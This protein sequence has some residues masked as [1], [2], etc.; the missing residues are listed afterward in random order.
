MTDR[1]TLTITR[2]LPGS[3]KSTAARRRRD[4]LRAA[5]H[6]AVV[7][8]RDPLRDQLGLT[9]GDTAGEKHVTAVRDAQVNTLLRAGVNVIV[10]EMNLAAQYVR[11][12]META[13]RA[14][15]LFSVLDLTDVDVELCVRR[16]TLRPEPMPGAVTGA[17]VGEQ[18]IRNQHRRFL[19]GKKLP[20]E[21]PKIHPTPVFLPYTLP[22]GKPDAILVDLDGTLCLHN[23]RDPYDE[24]RVSEDLPNWPVIIAVK[25]MQSA[26]HRIIY[27]SGRS[28]GCRADTHAW[29]SSY[30]RRPHEGL[31]MRAIGDSRKDLI[32][33]M[34]I[35]DR[36]IRHNYRVTGVFDDRASVVAGWR[37]IGLTVFQVAEGNF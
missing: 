9:Y 22:E 6:R 17:R 29:L 36:E 3:G 5:G 1:P 15:A 34:E 37:Q 20:L 12:W 23:G 2:G 11:H 33:K 25:A 32:V 10:D 21:L 19:A 16:D 35:F 14:G 30:V 31:F 28:A 7:V 4:Q 8:S 18:A 27:L 24:N 13:L 26:G